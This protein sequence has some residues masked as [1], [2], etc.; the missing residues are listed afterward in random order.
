MNIIM[1]RA[2]G[3]FGRSAH[4]VRSGSS[5]KS[6]F[7]IP[8]GE[9]SRPGSLVPSSIMSVRLRVYRTR[10]LKNLSEGAGYVPGRK[11][12][13]KGSSAKN[14]AS[15]VETIRGEDRVRPILAARGW[16]SGMERRNTDIW[17]EAPKARQLYDLVTIAARP[18]S[19]L[20]LRYFGHK[21]KQFAKLTADSAMPC[22]IDTLT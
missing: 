11:K 22:A 6:V 18:F 5:N 8:G 15:S 1:A 10:L 16:R 20:G 7:R 2:V 19:M 13:V 9:R 17:P 3:L 14:R 12:T 21:G 4:A